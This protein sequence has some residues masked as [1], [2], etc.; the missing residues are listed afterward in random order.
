MLAEGGEALPKTSL[1]P[2]PVEALRP[3]KGGEL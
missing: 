1:L 3:M 2:V